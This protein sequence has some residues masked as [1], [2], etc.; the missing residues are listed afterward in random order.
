MFLVILN[1]IGLYVGYVQPFLEFLNPSPPLA[2]ILYLIM[3]D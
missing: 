1:D 3:L 2:V